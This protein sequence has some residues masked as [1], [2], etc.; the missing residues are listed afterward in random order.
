MKNVL[1][2]FLF[3]FL[4][5]SLASCKGDKA[6]KAEVGDKAKV[7]A[8]S[9]KAYAVDAATSKVLW[10]GTK[11]TGAHNGSLNVSTGSVS[12]DNGNV[13]GGSFTLDMNSINVLDLQGGG[14]ADLEGHLKN[15][16]FFNTAKYPTGKFEITKI[17]GV[18]NDANA[19]HLVYGNLT[20]KD[21]T[22]EVGFKAKVAVNGNT[23]TVT[24][25]TF[26]IDRTL[27]G[28]NYKSNKIF[29]NLKDKFIDDNMKLSI[30]LVAKG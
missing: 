8:K 18:A 6:A 27:W 13:T 1:N 3:A 5:G 19:T 11:P 22:K 30:N 10:E 25:P 9:G 23:V 4:L 2:L 24:S 29:D 28:I 15:E 14:K 12:V 7:A 16:D 17:T 21:I 20:L 26:E